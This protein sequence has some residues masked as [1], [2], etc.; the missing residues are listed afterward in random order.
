MSTVDKVKAKANEIIREDGAKARDFA[1][2]AASSGAYIYPIKA[3]DSAHIAE[4]Q[5]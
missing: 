2:S 5:S 1:M 4:D 3:R